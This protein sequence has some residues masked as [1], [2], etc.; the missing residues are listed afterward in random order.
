MLVYGA[1]KDVDGDGHFMHVYPTEPF[2]L[3]RLPYSCIICQPAIFIRKK[4]VERVGYLNADLQCSMD[5]DL[6]IRCGLL[7]KENPNWKFIYVPNFWALNRFHPE[8]KSLTLRKKHIEITTDMVKRYFGFIPFN[9]VYGLEEVVDG[10]YD[11]IFNI[12]PLKTSLVLKSFVKWLWVNRRSPGHIV[13]FSINTMMS[14]IDSWRLIKQR[15]G[16]L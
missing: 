6:W 13:K 11:G 2:N 1:A 10:K 12:S 15:T 16:A 14:P 9:W 3:E 8:S 7:Q 5:L 4:L